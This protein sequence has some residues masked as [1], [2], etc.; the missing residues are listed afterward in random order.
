ME[1]LKRKAE[2]RQGIDLEARV[3]PAD[4]ITLGGDATLSQGRFVD[5]AVGH[6]YI[7][8]APNVTL[9][10]NAVVKWNDYSAALRL[11][12]IGDRPANTNNSIVAQG[13]SVFDLSL[14]HTMGNLE[15]YANIEN[16]FNVAWNEA[17]FATTSRIYVN[18]ALESEPVTDLDFTAGTPI[19]VRTGISYHF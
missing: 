18:G 4:W 13:Y 9:T 17:Q 1:L 6:D 19:S 10:A 15:I 8:L 7:P 12:H 2:H 16:L 5:S 3:R 14:S 11:R